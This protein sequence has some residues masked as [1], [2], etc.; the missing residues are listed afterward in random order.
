MNGE[1]EMKVEFTVG[2]VTIVLIVIA[3]FVYKLAKKWEEKRAI[4]S[5]D[6]T[7][8]EVDQLVFLINKR[9]IVE[10]SNY[11]EMNPEAKMGKMPNILGNVLH[12][13]NA[14]EA[15]SCGTSKHCSACRIRNTI[16]KSFGEKHGFD[17]LFVNMQLFTPQN[18]LVTAAVQVD[19]TYIEP[20]G[21]PRMI[22]DVKTLRPVGILEEE[23][24]QESES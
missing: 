8:R 15:G 19:G 12:C 20:Q 21:K 3:Y 4:S 13:K 14:V 1:K 16:K 7:P 2:I 18:K 9:F 22:I 5:V 17:H 11:F 24:K 23:N 10:K 6:I